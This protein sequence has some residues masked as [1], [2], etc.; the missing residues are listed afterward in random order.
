MLLWV[1]RSG[2]GFHQSV[3][4]SAGPRTNLHSASQDQSVPLRRPHACSGV[5]SCVTAAAYVEEALHK[6][7]LWGV[8]RALREWEVILV[9]STTGTEIRTP[10]PLLI[11]PARGPAKDG[12][13]PTPHQKVTLL[14]RQIGFSRSAERKA[15]SGNRRGAGVSRSER[16]H[17]RAAAGGGCRGTRRERGALEGVGG[18]AELLEG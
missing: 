8:P 6:R 10:T 11:R 5:R 12:R 9:S 7:A 14:G 18:H 3:D 16:G 2:G 1:V 15:E 17:A 4:R 13:S